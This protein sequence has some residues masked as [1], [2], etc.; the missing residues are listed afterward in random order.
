L[1]D[2]EKDLELLND[3][4]IT[5]EERKWLN[6]LQHIAN[7]EFVGI[8]HEVVQKEIR[9]MLSNYNHSENEKS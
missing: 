3:P 1:E 5:D 4:T 8:L 2:L 6:T 9:D 7:N